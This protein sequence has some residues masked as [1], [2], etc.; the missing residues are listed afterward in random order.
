M[1]NTEIVIS[2]SG[3]M[4]VAQDAEIAH[5]GPSWGVGGIYQAS[6]IRILGG[7]VFSRVGGSEALDPPPLL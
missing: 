1:I 7:W 3:P 4:H 5:L 2:N 6:F